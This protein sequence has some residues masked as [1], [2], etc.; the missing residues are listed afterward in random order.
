MRTSTLS[1]PPVLGPG[2]AA[3]DGVAGVDLVDSGLGVSM[4]LEILIGASV[5]QSRS[6]QYAVLV[7]VRR[8]RHAGDPLAG[9]DEAVEAGH[10][11][12]RREAVLARQRLAV[13][14]D[15]DHR[16]AAVERRASSGVL[17]VMPSTSVE[18]IWSAFVC[19]CRPGRAGR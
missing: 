6:V 15:R 16:V 14:A 8:Q 10:D 9:A 4:R 3:D 13:H 2:D 11:H 17:I 12:P 5:A 7:V 19:R 1:M 18:R